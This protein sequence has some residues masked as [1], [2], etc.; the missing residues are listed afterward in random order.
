MLRR[1]A[2]AIVV[3]SLLFLGNAAVFKT[4]PQNVMIAGDTDPDVCDEDPDI[5][6]GC[7]LGVC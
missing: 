1:C 3:L 7:P 4:R 6:S 2:I 5:C